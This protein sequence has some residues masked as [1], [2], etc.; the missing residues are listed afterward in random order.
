MAVLKA[1]VLFILLVFILPTA[2]TTVWWMLQERPNSWRSADWS[3]S[4]VLPVV[5]D[6][7]D[8]AV[9]VMAARLGGLKGAISV[10]SWIVTKEKGA[11]RY[12][13]YDVVGWGNP[14]R[15][16]GYPAD[17]RWY[18]NEPV[19]MHAVTGRQAEALI[20]RVEAAVNAYPYSRAGDYVVWPGP[21]SNSFVAWVLRQV[22][23]IGARMP[24]NA[25]GRDYAPGFFDI[26]WS[27]KTRDLH[28]TLGGFVGLAVGATSGFELHFLGVVAGI[29]VTEP[30]IKIPAFGRVDASILG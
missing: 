16:N 26:A 1:V 15:R 2:A 7:D 3:A 21:N 18:S 8:A 24:P 5:K 6:A 11:P 30:A 23:E 10:H 29:D 19:I 20:P 28:V 9:Y 12:N 17:G 4:G 14:V 27:P 22:P 25:T 13:R